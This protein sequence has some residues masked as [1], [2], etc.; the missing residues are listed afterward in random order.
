M[1]EQRSEVRKDR[2]GP[3]VQTGREVSDG[4]VCAATVGTVN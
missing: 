1:G 2:E 4:G 3:L